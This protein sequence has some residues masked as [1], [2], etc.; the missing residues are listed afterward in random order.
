MPQPIAKRHSPESHFI[1]TGRITKGLD[2]QRAKRLGTRFLG[3]TWHDSAKQMQSEGRQPELPL[4]T[5]K[6]RIRGGRQTASAATEIQRQI[7]LAVNLFGTHL[8]TEQRAQAIQAISGK[9]K[10]TTFSVSSLL[11]NTLRDPVKSLR[12]MRSEGRDFYNH[13]KETGRAYRAITDERTAKTNL[14][15]G[16]EKDPEGATSPIHEAVHSL[17]QMGLIKIDVPF[18]YATDRL[19]GL[20]TGILKPSAEMGK[21]TLKDFNRK[22]APEKDVQGAWQE[23]NWAERVGNGIGQWLFT[24]IHT[25]EKRWQ[26]LYHRTMGE[27]HQSALAK[28][29]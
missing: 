2:P 22:P 21:L 7:T 23:N 1:R 4:P 5:F 13:A 19:Y 11:H 3:R 15:K 9:F 25:P 26:Y 29:Q 8:T 10:K 6:Q 24:N 16:W 12:E 20:E 28:I 18:A 17:Q 14:A 27:S